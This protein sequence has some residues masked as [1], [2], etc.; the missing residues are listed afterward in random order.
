[1]KAEIIEKE[2]SYTLGGI[3]FK[4]QKELGRFS[5]ER[6]YAD[7]LEKK[8][9]EHPL[10]YAR[11]FPIEVAGRK[12]NFADFIVENKIVVELKAKPF[13][14]KPDF[15]QVRRYLKTGNLH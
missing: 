15:I 7:A 14:E 4:I 6:Q 13:I 11:E 3:F 2:L 12:S 10:S 9:K 8:L 1:M 5:R